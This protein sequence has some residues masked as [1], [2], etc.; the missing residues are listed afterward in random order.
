MVHVR[1]MT[2]SDLPAFL[3]LVDSLADYERLRRPDAQARERLARDVLA[4]PPRFSCLLAERAG[5]IVGY[6]AFFETYSTFL[7]QPTL[8]LEDIFVLEE[9]R[10]R[11]LGRAFMVE[12]AR[13]AVRRGCGRIEW[14]VLTWNRPAIAFYERLEAKR[15]EAWHTYRLTQEEFARLAEGL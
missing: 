6:A 10:S 15:L 7:A 5:R 14:Q 4:D 8:Y 9:E 3:G 1:P 11:G 12:L 2:S 13:E